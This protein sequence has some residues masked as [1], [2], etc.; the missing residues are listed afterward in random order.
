MRVKEKFIVDDAYMNGYAKICGPMATCVYLSLCR[1]AG[2]TQ[3]SFPSLVRMADQ[4]GVH[5]TTIIR[6][7][8]ILERHRIIRVFSVKSVRGDYASNIYVLLDKQHWSK[9]PVENP[10]GVVA[11]SDYGS[12]R[13][14]GG[15]VAQS[16][17]KDTHKKDTHRRKENS[18]TQGDKYPIRNTDTA[19]DI[20]DILERR[21]KLFNE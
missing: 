6:S 7:I 4:L 2:Q 9:T 13:K 21:Y 18:F 12:S 1:H 8:K 16:D 20:D 10:R 17:S 19:E 3:E 5:R 15:V 11:Q 14:Y